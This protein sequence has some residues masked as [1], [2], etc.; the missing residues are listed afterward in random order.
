MLLK[1]HAVPWRQETDPTTGRPWK[2]LSPSYRRRKNRTHP[3]EPILRA[4]G[5]MQD[6]AEIVPK[7]RGFDVKTT[8]YGA[9]H[10]FGTLKM[11]AR[12]WVGIP[13]T[14]LQKIV[15]IAWK[16]ILSSKR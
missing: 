11:T 13:D 1:D 8:K 7:G 6:T 16:N 5:R 9:Y 4:T 15:P 10:Q 14:S 2:A 12:P 3:G